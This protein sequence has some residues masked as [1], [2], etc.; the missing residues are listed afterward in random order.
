MRGGRCLEGLVRCER[1]RCLDEVGDSGEG[2][3]GGGGESC[4][5]DGG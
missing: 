4:C 5:G 1:R 3:E 2:R